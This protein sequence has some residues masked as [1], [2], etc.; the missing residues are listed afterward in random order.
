MQTSETSSLRNS[1]ILLVDDQPE[2]IDVIK[3]A[4]DQHF[5]LKIAIKGEIALKIAVMGGIDLILLDIMM[6]ELD[7]YEV[8]RQ[9]KQN[10]VTAEVPIIFLTSKEGHDDEA[11]G[12]KLGAVDYIRKPSNPWVVLA[13]VQN[14]IAYQR[15]KQELNEKNLQLQQAI[16]IREDVERISQHDL[17]GPLSGIIG[18]VEVLLDQESN[19]DPWQ[20]ELVKMV[21][22]SS[23]TI[24]E[25]INKSLD[26][27]KMEN[28][29]YQLNP[30]P[31][32][33]L[34]VLERIVIDLGPY[35][36]PDNI[37]LSIER[38]A[39]LNH[40]IPFLVYGEKLLCYS[41]FYNLLLNA[42]EASD[43]GSVIT[44][45]LAQ[46]HDNAI[47]KIT[48]PGEVPLAIQEYFFDKYVTSGKRRGTGLGTYSA[49]LA[50][51]TQHGNIELDSRQKQ[52]TTVVVS[53]P[54]NGPEHHVEQKVA[55]NTL[56]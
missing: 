38:T 49:L 41:L 21:G 7:G 26:L 27:F 18:I 50:A 54:M 51:K 11:S 33:L 5:I 35:S 24:L 6:P 36:T 23:Y 45:L 53:L 15:A 44:I 17:K 52:Q 25:M 32:D 10:P 19:L 12:L 56:R 43:K 13:R 20:T 3:S 39:P 9:L 31:F 55:L 4:L 14:T 42:V 2:S 8:C 22:T 1:T 29:S 16:T 37:T 48:N 47:I 34:E 46:A 30:E 28:G 40:S